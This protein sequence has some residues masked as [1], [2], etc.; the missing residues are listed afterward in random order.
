VSFIQIL[1]TT[2]LD[3]V[4]AVLT[5]IMGVVTTVI[6]TIIANPILLIGLAGSLVGTA[7]MVFKKMK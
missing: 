6:N 7:I 5:V 3:S 1:G 2:Q 4:S